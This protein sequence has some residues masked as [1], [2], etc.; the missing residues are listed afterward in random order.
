MW[1]EAKS[2]RMSRNRRALKRCAMA[3]AASHSWDR[4]P[5]LPRIKATR[6]RSG[7]A[8]RL[9]L[10]KKMTN[11][12]C[13]FVR[14][15]RAMQIYV[16]LPCP[17]P[18]DLEVVKER[19]AASATKSVMVTSKFWQDA[20]GC[21]KRASVKKCDIRKPEE[22]NQQTNHN[23]PIFKIQNLLIFKKRKHESNS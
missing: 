16:C 18:K 15:K 8:L 21:N 19:P 23:K 1:S 22:T 4:S 14:L 13:M 6:A 7:Y 9:V 2:G 11:L 12:I 10:E 17:V 20:D 3:T 5:R